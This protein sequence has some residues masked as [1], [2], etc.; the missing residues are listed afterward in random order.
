MDGLVMQRFLIVI[1]AA[2][3]LGATAIFA[4]DVRSSRHQE[5]RES[6]LAGVILGANV[7][8][9]GVGPSLPD[10]RSTLLR[11]PDCDVASQCGMYGLASATLVG[12][13]SAD[14]DTN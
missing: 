10:V 7:W 4:A 1:A 6:V 5:L 8:P 14:V 11:S 12:G 3:S 13:R 2:G 9:Y